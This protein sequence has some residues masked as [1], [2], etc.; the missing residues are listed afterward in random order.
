M[1]SRFSTVPPD[2]P[3]VKATNLTHLLLHRPTVSGLHDDPDD[4][5]DRADVQALDLVDGG[6]AAPYGRYGL[7]VLEEL[8]L[9]VF[10]ERNLARVVQIVEPLVS[11]L[12]LAAADGVDLPTVTTAKNH[13]Q[14]APPR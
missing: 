7:V 11:R 9:G 14:P 10:V 3:A 4:V 2:C 13:H 8:Y 5:N 1:T 12:D 6:E